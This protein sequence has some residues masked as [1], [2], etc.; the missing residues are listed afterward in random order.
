[1]KQEVKNSNL[2]S[3]EILTRGEAVKKLGSYAALTALGT[4]MILNPQ[5][6]QAQ[7]AP[8]GPGGG[9]GFA[10][11]DGD[12]STCCPDCYDDDASTPCPAN[13]CAG[14]TSGKDENCSITPGCP[15]GGGDPFTG[16]S[17]NRSNTTNTFNFKS[18]YKSKYKLKYKKK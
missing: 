17:N 18:N 14:N 8:P 2:N 11:S 3:T 9:G 5:K 16:N 4:F 12:T 6:A 10:C 7:S 1:M 15:P 13:E